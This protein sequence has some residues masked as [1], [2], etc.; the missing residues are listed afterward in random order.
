MVGPIRTA[1]AV[2]VLAGSGLILTLELQRSDETMVPVAPSN[3]LLQAEPVAGSAVSAETHERW[4]ARILARPLF[5]PGRRPQAA[6]VVA[7]QAAPAPTLPRVAGIV[8]MDG[9][10]RVIFAG[11]GAG[12]EL[13]LAE[14]ADV[15]GFRVQSIEPG[16][17]TVAG[18]GGTRT[19]LTSFDA[20]RPDGPAA[21][22]VPLPPPAPPPQPM[23]ISALPAILPPQDAVPGAA[24][25][26][27]GLP[28]PPPQVV[29]LPSSGALA[30]GLQ[31]P[32]LPL[33]PPA[34]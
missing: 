12:R 2:A 8:V 13:V 1:L 22:P 3:H 32:G 5:T 17:G 11:A 14:G 26:P 24:P 18:P 31:I 30:N 28:T 20:H 16:R 29:G 19:L 6:A 34:R 27:N 25:L 23:S 7:Q 9:S 4:V 10:K 15:T 33:A 21:L